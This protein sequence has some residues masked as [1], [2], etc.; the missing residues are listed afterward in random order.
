MDSKVLTT[1]PLRTG[2]DPVNV[3]SLILNN[4]LVLFT[5]QCKV[6]VTSTGEYKCTHT[7][8][9]LQVSPKRALIYC[10]INKSIMEGQ[11]L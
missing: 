7:L 3:S 11:I 5:A 8:R 10:I 1:T 2:P 4:K 9:H 6:A